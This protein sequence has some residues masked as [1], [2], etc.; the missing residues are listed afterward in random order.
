MNNSNENSTT[1]CWIR[2]PGEIM[3][4]LLLKS[5]VISRPECTYANWRKADAV[6]WS[7]PTYCRTNARFVMRTLQSTILTQ[8]S[9]GTLLRPKPV[10]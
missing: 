9:Y 3:I 2:S 5:R 4:L 1:S 8:M 10:V 7:I 6:P